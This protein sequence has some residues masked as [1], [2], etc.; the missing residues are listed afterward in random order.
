MP[1]RTIWNLAQCSG[2]VTSMSRA[3]P[4]LLTHTHEGGAGGLLGQRET[5]GLVQ[6]GPVTR[7]AERN[8]GDSRGQHARAGAAVAKMAVEMLVA[9]LDK[10]AGQLKAFCKVERPLQPMGQGK[11]FSPKSLDKAP[12]RRSGACRC[13]PQQGRR[14]GRGLRRHEPLGG[15]GFLLGDGVQSVLGRGPAH[16]KGADFE[17]TLSKRQDF[18]QD[19]GMGYGGIPAREISNLH[20][21]SPTQKAAAAANRAVRLSGSIVS[22]RPKL[23]PSI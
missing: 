11:A 18:A 6:F 1:Q 15:G 19:K 20:T 5:C 23:D 10:P 16:G 13:G 22:F 7:H 3:R 2:G 17:S 14:V 21:G 9:A 4:Y 12:P 8:A